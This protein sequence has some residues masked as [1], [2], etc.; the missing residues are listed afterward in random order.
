MN[1]V[2]ASWVLPCPGIPKPLNNLGEPGAG[3]AWL[4]S[5]RKNS[6]AL[7]SFVLFFLFFFETI[8]LFNRFF[9]LP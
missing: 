8:F 7:G 4:A 6:G 3:R 9:C 1:G 2:T 5:G